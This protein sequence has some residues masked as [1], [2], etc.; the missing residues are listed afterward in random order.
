MHGA[1][2]LGLQSAAIFPER[3]PVTT[4]NRLGCI[5]VQ[6]RLG[7]GTR[8]SAKED[9]WGDS[10]RRMEDSVMKRCS[11]CLWKFLKVWYHLDRDHDNFLASMKSLWPTP[12]LDFAQEMP[13]VRSWSVC[14][15]A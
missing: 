7:V 15:R 8:P 14:R 3:Y 2:S 10:K 13:G 4:D 5:S 6:T 1:T 12:A 11:M 9:G